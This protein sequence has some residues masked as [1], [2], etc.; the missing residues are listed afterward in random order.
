MFEK[1]KCFILDMDGTIYL[2]N[3][4]FSF[5]KDFLKKLKKQGENIISLRIILRKASKIILRNLKGLESGSK[6]SK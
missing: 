4:L 6:G 3:E 2:G 5:T 1:I